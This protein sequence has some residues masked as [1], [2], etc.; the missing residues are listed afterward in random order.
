MRMTAQQFRDYMARSEPVSPRGNPFGP[1][2]NK[3]EDLKRQC[4]D[5]CKARGWI[6]LSGSMAHRTHRTVGEA[7]LTVLA[8]SGRVFFIELKLPG[9]KQSTDQLA[10]QAWMRKLGHKYHLAHTLREFIDLVTWA[11]N[12]L[13]E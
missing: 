6:V 12:P 7:D 5:Y 1:T 8:D 9:R 10:L 2:P 13:L 3:E 4:S 11:H